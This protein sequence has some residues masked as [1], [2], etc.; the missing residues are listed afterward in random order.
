[1]LKRHAKLVSFALF[2]LDQLMTLVA[3]FSAFWFLR[4]NPVNL[5]T[6]PLMELREYSWLL[7]LIVPLWTVCLE[8]SGLYA[9]YRTVSF[10]R[11][12]ANIVRG[13]ILCCLSLFAGLA[14]TKSSHVSRPFFALFPTIHGAR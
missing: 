7:L 11:E 10:W 2:A 1:M 14:L 9:S 4:T 5:P 13:L 3:F 12:F 8:R 6:G